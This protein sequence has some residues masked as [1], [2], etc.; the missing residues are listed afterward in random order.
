M[1]ISPDGKISDVNLATEKIIGIKRKKLIGTDFAGYFTKPSVAREGYKTVF[2]KGK[3]R[4]YAL[5]ILHKSGRRIDVLFNATIFRNEEGMVQGVFA[6][7]RDITERKKMEEELRSSKKLL[8]T[9]NQH[10]NDIRE[11]ERA[12][13]SREIHDELGQSLT[14]LKLDLNQFLK[15]VN[16]N[17]EAVMKLVSMNKLIL[18]TIKNVQRISSDLRPGILDDLG[19]VPAI[20]WY[21]DEF[22]KRTGIICTHKL[23]N[24][25]YRESMINIIFFRIL[26][27]SLTNVIRHSKASSVYVNLRQTQKGAILTIKDNGIGIP[28]EKIESHKSLGLIIMRERVR[29]LNGK[30]DITSK[31]GKGTMLTIFIPSK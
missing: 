12:L 17:P 24:I 13:I 1:T 9:L 22:E 25:D 6:N 5:T 10:L 8:E 29:L 4:D 18:G 7:A 15:Y 20:E 3:V 30:L 28:E 27:E 16:K 19:L 21:C 26:Q 2:K 14:A 31:E 23:E 11:N